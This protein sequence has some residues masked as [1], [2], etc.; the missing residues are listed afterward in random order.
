MKRL[1]ATAIALLTVAAATLPARAAGAHVHHPRRTP[2]I[3]SFTA[4]RP[5][6]DY[7]GGTVGVFA[8]VHH[9]RRC[10]IRTS[11]PLPTPATATDCRDGDAAWRLTLPANSTRTQ[12]H[13]T[14]TLV[15][16]ARHH[17]AKAALPLTVTAQPPPCPGETDPA[18]PS[19]TALFTDPSTHNPLDQTPILDAE[20]NLI[21]HAQLPV[22]GHHTQIYVADF[23]YT[24]LPVTRALAWAHHFMRADV[25]LVLDGSNEHLQWPNGT[26]VPNPAY[27]QAV[28]RLPAG[29]VVACG[30][31]AGL[32]G[33]PT[34]AGSNDGSQVFP[35][36][37]GCAGNN[38]MH[39]KLLTVSSIDT[40]GD[41]AVLTTSQNLSVNALS[42]AFNDGL[43]LDGS[44]ALY[45]LDSAYI[46]SMAA[47]R[48]DA[49][50][51][52]RFA[53]SP[54]TVGTATTASVFGPR[55]ITPAFPAKRKYDA[56][57]DQ[58]TD[59][60]AQTLGSVDCGKPG[61]W[62]GVHDDGPTRSLIRI[63]MFSYGDR[64]AVTAALTALAADGCD[65]GVVYGSIDPAARSALKAAGVTLARLNVATFP[66]S[67]G[68]GSGPVFV[69]DKYLLISGGLET[70]TGTDKNQTVVVTGSPN[71]TQSA[72]H[73]DDEAGVTYQEP[74]TAD[75][76]SAP[77]YRA[78]AAHWDHL[79][80]I[81]AAI[82]AGAPVA[83]HAPQ[84]R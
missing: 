44:H 55:N 36:G 31:N 40:A 48:P 18:T 79:A 16:S 67:D 75:L 17:R 70:T 39:A 27:D 52:D 49:D 59:T 34:V 53:G 25:L 62:A 56:A 54:V 47:D 19:T 4:G 65:V 21:C 82:P 3:A 32:T 35:A 60:V 61:K 69:H 77:V 28:K 8:E 2:K 81:A 30:P 43:E 68:T 78:Y 51:G 29:S 1:A 72:L 50:F 10:K 5:R 13:Y 80:A 15:A 33:R 66:Y 73:N 57:N 76:A 22:A 64:Q 6:L 26:L 9:A 14:V 11:P 46:A 58:A 38:I 7:V 74:I 84:R 45:Q 20:I 24:L 37:T 23:A 41:P 63:A 71:L 12:A 83:V 42:A